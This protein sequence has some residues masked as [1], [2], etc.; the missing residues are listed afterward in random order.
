MIWVYMDSA[1]SATGWLLK[2]DGVDHSRDL[3][4][5]SLILELSS[6]AHTGQNHRQQPVV[7]DTGGLRSLSLCPEDQISVSGC[8]KGAALLS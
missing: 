6:E 2:A 1:A 4:S 3:P 7:R 5:S 8:G